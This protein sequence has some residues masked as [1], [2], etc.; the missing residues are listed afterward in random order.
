MAH[1]MPSPPASSNRTPPGK[2]SALAQPMLPP[3]GAYREAT[4]AYDARLAGLLT[5]L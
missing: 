2:A 5:T 1:D 4:K 3:S